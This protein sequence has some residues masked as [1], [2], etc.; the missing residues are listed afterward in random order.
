MRKKSTSYLILD[1]KTNF[2]FLLKFPN[3]AA[4]LTFAARSSLPLGFNFSLRTS[5]IPVTIITGF[6]GSGKTT[7]LNRLIAGNPH[8][9]FAVIENEFGEIGIDNELVEGVDDGI[10]EMSNGC[11]CCTLN[12]ELVE[13]LSK[14]LHS[15][16]KFDHLLIETTGIAEPDSVAAAFVTDPSVQEYFRLNAVICLADAVNIEDMLHEREEAKRQVSFADYILLN[17][18]TE[19]SSDYLLKLIAMLKEANPLAAVAAGDFAE[20]P[21]DLLNLHA[22][23]AK[24]VEEKLREQHRPH[25]H[26]HHEHHH[27]HHHHEDIVSHSFIFDQPFDMLKLRHWMQVLLMLQGEAIYRV[28]GVLDVQWQDKKVILQSVRKAYSFSVGEEW[29]AGLPH[30][31]RIVFIGKK[32]RKDILEKN[33]K[34]LMAVSV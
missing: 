18:K 28:K 1:T 23:E 5:M 12:D 3:F 13:I 20:S 16:K 29:P 15:G 17:K 30:Q 32:L 27:H 9:K 6:L 25:G 2:S 4:L 26:E 7:L 34:N 24:T 11:I 19:V 33:L 22:Y 8:M 10:F 14:L 31:S 21:D